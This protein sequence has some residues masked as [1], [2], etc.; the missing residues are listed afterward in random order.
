[1]FENK[2]CRGHMPL[3]IAVGI[4]ILVLLLA[5]G[6]EAAT[7]TVNASGG[8]D[9][10]KIQDAVNAASPG[11]TIL[12]NSN[13]YYENVNVNKQL[14]LRGVDTGSGK[15]VVDAGRSG[16]AIKLSAD[17]VTIYGFTATNSS[18]GWF[19]ILLEY[20]SN[21]IVTNNN[22]SNN[23]GGGIYGIWSSNNA[24]TNNTANNNSAGIGF[25]SSDNNII[26]SN[27]VDNNRGA[28]IWLYNTG[29][30]T[31]INNTANNSSYVG[32]IYLFGA[33]NS[34]ISNNT[35]NNNNG[36][37]I[38][39]E[40]DSNS[41]ITYNDANNNNV[42][43]IYLLGATNGT[44][45]YNDANNNSNY[46]IYFFGSKAKI[47][48]NIAN[49]N[50]ECGISL[51]IASNSDNSNNIADNNS[52][53]G[54]YL[55]DV[56]NS[57]ITDNDANN[58]NVIGIDME[59][60]SNNT[61]TNNNANNNSNIGIYLWDSNNNTLNRNI[62]YYNDQ[63]GI[64]VGYTSKN[65]SIY[66]NFFNNTNN[67]YFEGVS[68]K[69]TWN[70]TII[71]STNIIGGPY[72]GGNFW[73]NPSATGFSQTCID[74]EWDGIC[75]S[76]YVL[77]GYNTDYLPLSMNFTSTGRVHNINKG[78][79]YTTIQTATGDASPGDEIHVDS[80]TYR[81]NVNVTKQL[82]LRGMDTGSGKPVVD[83]G[84]SSDAIT[85]SADGITLDGFNATNASSWYAG[86]MVTSNNNTLNRNDI[87]KNNY[88]INLYYSRNNTVN[89][90]NASANGV[91]IVLYSSGNST[92]KGN[93]IT[94][95][96]YSVYLYS[97]SD[98]N[99]FYDNIFNSTF[100]LGLSG[101]NNNTWN[102][103]KIASANIIG[104]SYLAG[105][106]WAHPD[107][108]GF[109]QTCMDSNID[110]ICDS[111]YMLSTGNED[112]LPLAIPTGYIN[113]S[114]KYNNT[115]ITGAVI[116]T[117]TGAATTT[118]SSGFYS[119][120]LP[121]GT[122][123]LIATREPEYYSNSSIAGTVIIGT[124]VIAQDINLIKKPAGNIT[125]IVSLV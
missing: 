19:G 105:N 26:L 100:N 46:G 111:G 24:V 44:I 84:R 13:T 12:V 33:S 1:M 117:N 10:T 116:A 67:F 87:S 49:N 120:Q 47:S 82:I 75:D 124:T 90:N 76:P 56:S 18:G 66:N 17:G 58:N 6:A 88:G 69:N 97:S 14:T 110:G 112:Y 115:G 71:A 73:A 40:S 81:E 118:D 95:N 123:Q 16:N 39:I 103:T 5:G 94:N 92:L 4:T 9:Y 52:Y 119:L 32:S 41:T 102:T 109:S 93:I 70:T 107:G 2:V 85:L 50:R 122:Y 64:K 62:A 78:T 35:A 106:F 86:I 89:G 65:N 53:C 42:T 79:N 83:A 68:S 37:G 61:I 101:M 25:E 60:A 80:G 121:A 21:N 114:V 7:I 108:T 36:S 98:N 77:D 48:Y 29:N 91:G 15:P 74:A 34:T 22:V 28:G 104:G 30:S 11:D 27:N 72:L 38:Y 43:G 113:G 23:R 8:G 54:I 20:S 59:R 31:I 63:Y 125:G 55:L 96:S 51:M 3:R 57:T 45:T 99:T